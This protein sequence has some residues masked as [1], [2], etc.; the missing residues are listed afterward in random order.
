MRKTALIASLLLALASGTAHADD[1]YRLW[2]RYAETKASGDA[3]TVQGS[4]PS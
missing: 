1:G 2:L 4:S 3:V